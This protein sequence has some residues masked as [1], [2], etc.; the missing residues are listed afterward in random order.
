V[1]QTTAGKMIFGRYIDPNLASQSGQ[2]PSVANDRE[3]RKSGR[4]Q[5][6]ASLGNGPA[7]AGSATN[8]T[9]SAS[10][11]VEFPASYGE[12]SPKQPEV[13]SRE[14]GPPSPIAPVAPDS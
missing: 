3:E 5:S 1:L 11:R 7:T 6:S 4:I 2:T 9:P 10:A 14:G 8:R 13:T 12:T